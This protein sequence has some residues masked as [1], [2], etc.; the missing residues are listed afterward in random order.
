MMSNLPLEW[1]GHYQVTA[2]V[3]ESLPAT[4]GQRYLLA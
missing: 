3:S 4:Q 1:T 2:Y